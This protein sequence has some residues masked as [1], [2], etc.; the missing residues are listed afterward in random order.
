MA[1]NKEGGGGGQG[2]CGKALGH[3]NYNPVQGI[4]KEQEKQEEGEEAGHT[5]GRQ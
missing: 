1:K 4:N 5:L 2:I 3:D